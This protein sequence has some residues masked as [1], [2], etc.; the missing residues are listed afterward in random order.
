MQKSKIKSVKSLGAKP[1]F[2]LTMK[3]DQHN[4][5]L[6]DA[7]KSKAVISGN[8]HAVAYTHTSS[9]LLYLKAHYPL[10]FFCSTLG[11]EA[12]EDKVK[13][14]KREAERSGIK[15]NRCDLNKSKVNYEIIDD[16]IYIG[17]SNI[18]GIGREVAEKIVQGQPYASINDF[19]NRFGT[20]K[21]IVEPLINLGVFKDAPP[22]VLT[23]FYED[24]KKWSKGNSDKEKR[25]QKRREE[26]AESIRS[27]LKK[28]A[29]SEATG[30]EVIMKAY[31]EGEAK[32]IRLWLMPEF[33]ERDLM[34]LVKKY[35]KSVLNF[36]HKVNFNKE[37]SISLDN[38]K[39][40]GRYPAD[41]WPNIFE[42]ERDHYGFS[43]EHP[44][45]KSVDYIGGH[46]FNIFKSDEEIVNAGVEVM[47]TKKPQEKISKN[48][49]RYYYVLVEDEDW[50]VEVVTFWSED[51]VRFKEEL[52]YWNEE[53][54]RGNFLRMR[55][56]K[57]GVGFKS[58]TFESPSKAIRH[59]VI[60][61][62]KK[63][64]ARLQ[65]MQSPM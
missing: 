34:V 47:I 15:I 45:Q 24:Y 50:N 28:E 30:H 39:P 42:L 52:E 6:Y 58:Y 12:D 5:L 60:P 35:A 23:E 43:W 1:V 19:L 56:T 62:D 33:D 14:Y 20:D 46:S 61:A 48:N 31:E 3:A 44:I 59:K 8:S 51:Y 2:D 10:E 21:R 55:V 36:E 16:E 49:N 32:E 54:S 64:D 53:Q 29:P 65:V 7:S 41:K 11:L 37:N 9:R 22:N 27:L 25:N 4:Y 26:L 18:K 17:F 38:W 40:Q 57:P 63:M 13:M